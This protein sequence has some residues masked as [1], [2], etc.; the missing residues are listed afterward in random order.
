MHAR[1]HK[2]KAYNYIPWMYWLPSVTLETATEY[3]QVLNTEPLHNR[4]GE[5]A[6]I[7]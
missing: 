4:A 1:T 3:H 6:V 2:S 5:L 7:S